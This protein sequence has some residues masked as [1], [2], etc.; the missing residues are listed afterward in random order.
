MSDV[1]PYRPWSHPDRRSSR[2]LQRLERD[3]ALGM[4]GM[5]TNADLAARRLEHEAELQALRTDAL[6]YV[7]SGCSPSGGSCSKP[8]T[9]VP[10]RATC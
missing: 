2:E 8:T 10:S 1:Q 9:P 5:A 7:A 4:A 3:R 6:T